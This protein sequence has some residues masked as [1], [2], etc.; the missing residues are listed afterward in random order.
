MKITKVYINKVVKKGNWIIRRSD[1]GKSHGGFVWQPLGEWTEAPDWNPS[2]ECGGGLHGNGPKT[3]PSEC[4]WSDGSRLEFCEVG[5]E[6]VRVYGK[7][8]GKIKCRKARILMINALPD[9][10]KVGGSLYLRGCTGLTA[11]PEGLKV[12]G[13]LDLRGCTGLTALPDGLKVSGYLDLSRCTGLTAL[14]DGLTVGGDLDLS[15][16]TGLTA[17]P[18][19]LTVGGALYLSY[20][21]GLTAL[22]KG[23]TVGWSLYLSGC[24][25]LTALPKGLTVGGALYL[26]YCTGLKNVP[27]TL[28]GVK[29][30][31]Y[32]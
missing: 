29:G 1:N 32:K 28:P 22:P 12:G 2:L 10:L 11:L 13:D 27:G 18:K 7:P 14:P 20:C 5:P 19:G 24:T 15:R 16:C 30:R 8:D 25:G 31:I 17:L 9:G 26:S 23:L 21:T 3:S 6:F 4:H